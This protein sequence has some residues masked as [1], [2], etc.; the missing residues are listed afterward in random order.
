MANSKTYAPEIIK[1]EKDV[2]QVAC[3]GGGG[4]LGHPIVWYSFDDQDIV[5]CGYCD[6]MFI[7]K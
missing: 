3:D 1:V 5:E 7:K 4:T 6:R 2:D